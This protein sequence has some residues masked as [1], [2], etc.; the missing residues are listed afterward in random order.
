[1]SPERV[2]LAEDALASD[3][4]VTLYTDLLDDWNALY[5]RLERAA[6]QVHGMSEKVEKPELV[7]HLRGQSEALFLATNFMREYRQAPKS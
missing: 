2:D 1:M 7:S 5:R 4:P 3:D 6:V